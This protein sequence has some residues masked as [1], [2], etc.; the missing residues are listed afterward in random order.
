MNHSWR[1]SDEPC[2]HV[3]GFTCPWVCSWIRSSP[4]TDAALSACA[5]CSRVSGSRKPVSTACAPQT[6]ARQSACS[7][8]AYGAAPGAGVPALL[9]EAEQVLDVVP[10]LVRD[11]VHLRERAA[12]G[13]ESRLEVV[14]EAEIEVDR[15]VERAVERPDRARS[16]RRTA[17]F[18]A[19]VKISTPG[20]WNALAGCRE[21]SD[22]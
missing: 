18:T 21:G 11:D 10:V 17:V 16:P 6:P 1:C 9:E 20:C 8:V 19:S 22:Q 5:I 14:V 2:V 15:L 3:S 4:M 13:P 12:L 7:S